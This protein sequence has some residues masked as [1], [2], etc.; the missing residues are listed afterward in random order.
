MVPRTRKLPAKKSPE[1]DES[2]PSKT[3]NKKKKHGY[4]TRNKRQ[5]NLPIA[6]SKA[7]CR[8]PAATK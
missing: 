6:R 3:N 4:D 2:R 5:M 7:Y 1:T 8:L